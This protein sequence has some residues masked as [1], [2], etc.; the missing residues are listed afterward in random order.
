MK[1]MKKTVLDPDLAKVGAALRRA[2]KQARR[3]A[4]LT[5]TPLVVYQQGQ[6]V[7]KKMGRRKDH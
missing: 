5:D 3:T 7:R 2:A 1:A 6:V 4:T